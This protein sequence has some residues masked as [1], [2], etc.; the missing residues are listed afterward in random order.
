MLVPDPPEAVVSEGVEIMGPVRTPVKQVPPEKERLRMSYEEF[1]AWA[2]E[3]VHAEWVNGEVIIHV[4]PKDIHQNLVR[5]LAVLLD[6]YV[7]FFRLGQLRFAP[8]EMKLAPDGPSRQ[9]DILF[10]AKEHLERLTEDRLIGPADLVVEVVSA[11]S[12]RRDL[13]EK[14][15][16]YERYGVREY[17]LVDSRP[18]RRGAEFWVRDEEGRFQ[19]ADVGEEGVYRST[20][21]PGFWLRLAWLQ[22]DPLPDP[23]LTFAEMV[24]FPPEAMA[25]LRDLA[26]KGP[27]A[28]GA[29]A[30]RQ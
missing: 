22:A 25:A 21:V 3:D 29:E 4:P 12:V 26:A 9:P 20:V 1:L 30:S 24:G 8:F 14:F 19:A 10:V 6:L 23:L 28:V 15:G 5:F 7:Q 11:D 27:R 2:D 17:W 13:V 18:G 16:E